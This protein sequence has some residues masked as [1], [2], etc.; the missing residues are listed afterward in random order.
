MTKR[1]DERTFRE[2]MNTPGWADKVIAT[3]QLW[4]VQEYRDAVIAGLKEA[5]ADPELIEHMANIGLEMWEDPEY[6]AKQAEIRSGAEWRANLSEHAKARYQNEAFAKQAR[7]LRQTADYRDKMRDIIVNSP[8]AIKYRQS[9]TWAKNVE[10]L[11]NLAKKRNNT[12]EW[13]AERS[14]TSKEAWQ[15]PEYRAKQT[16]I[17]RQ[18]FADPA[19][20]GNY[21]GPVIGINYDTSTFIVVRGA[22]DYE[23][24]NVVR[25]TVRIALN[26]D[27]KQAVGFTWMRTTEEGVAEIAGL[28]YKEITNLDDGKR[29]VVIVGYNPA[30]KDRVEFNRITDAKNAGWHIGHVQNSIN[31]GKLH[32]GYQWSKEER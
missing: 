16:E 13:R 23:R 24:K 8:A 3:S 5:Y 19:N 29:K 2:K 17:I 27:S 22:N 11:A 1:N 14:R 28:G 4:E 7:E 10:H 9:D 6:I 25:K 21:L 32:K 30:T 18:R 12:P 20:H 26:S 31:T 15:N